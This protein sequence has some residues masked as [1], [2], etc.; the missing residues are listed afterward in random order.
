MKKLM[1]LFLVPVFLVVGCDGGDPADRRGAAP[2]VSGFFEHLARDDHRFLDTLRVTSE[3]LGEIAA[4]ERSL[5]YALGRALEAR[6]RWA[7]AEAAYEFVVDAGLS[8]WDGFAAARRARRAVAM[9]D[10]VAAH[11][12][13][14]RGLEAQPDNRDLEFYRNEALYRLGEY[15]QLIDLLED[16]PPLAGMETGEEITASRLD[17]ERGLW[18]AVARFETDPNATDEFLDAFVKVPAGEIHPRLY[19]YLFYRDDGLSRFAPEERLLLEG[20]YRTAQREYSEAAR[21]LTMIEPEA[22]RR[23]LSNADGGELQALPGVFATIDQLAGTR[24]EGVSIWLERVTTDAIP[25]LEQRV[26]LLRARRIISGGDSGGSGPGDALPIL[27]DLAADDASGEVGSVMRAAARDLYLATRINRGDPLFDVVRALS[28]LGASPEEF[29]LAVDRLLPAR[30]RDR[31]WDGVAASLGAL[32]ATADGAAEH[33]AYVLA[34]AGVE[35]DSE[36][37]RAALGAVRSRSV[38]DFFGL[39]ARSAVGEVGEFVDRGTALETGWYRRAPSPAVASPAAPA[40]EPIVVDRIDRDDWRQLQLLHAD[41]LITAGRPDA[42][43]PLAMRAALGAGTETNSGR[44]VARR[45]RD[46]ARRFSAFGHYSAGLDV[47]RRAYIRGELELEP[48]D[49]QLLYPPAFESEIAA[50]AG[51]YDI[52]TAILNGLVREESHFRPTAESH[53]GARGLAQLMP[54]TADD[55]L[56]RLGDE[57]VDLDDPSENLRLGAFYLDYLN[58]QLPGSA[59]IQIAAYNAGLGRGRRW[60]AEFGDLTPLLQIEA[61]PFVETRWYLRRVTVSAAIYQWLRDGSSLEDAF[62]SIIEGGGE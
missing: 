7:G 24:Y 39:A 49:V 14:T 27:Y 6:G 55:I 33:L 40:I 57:T 58:E 30:V 54:A 36:A 59:V 41:A 56:R 15:G 53:V 22:F 12:W 50:A 10:L 61:L 11:A 19:L 35:S 46:V 60:I 5:P 31:D 18:N 13:A 4:Q 52:S 47:A 17:A 48:S 28:E 16:L 8:P 9:G 1:S 42:A 62:R 45:A 29:E 3:L 21:L 34:L 38:P 51:I 23:Y 25:F 44:A 37:Q 26:A 2:N 32:P 43:L 20:V